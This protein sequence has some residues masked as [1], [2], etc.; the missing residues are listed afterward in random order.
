MTDEEYKKLIAKNIKRL[1]YEN[2]KTQS[3]I[4]RDL[5][6]KQPTV[7]SWMNGT[8]MIQMPEIDLL[9]NYFNCK[10]IDIMEENAE[11]RTDALSSDERELLRLYRKLNATGRSA[12]LEHASDLSDLPKYT[13]ESAEGKAG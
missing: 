8:R 13:Q 6:L 7:S 3:D 5:G 9:C 10:R 1:A 11:T 2:H 4:V 12:L